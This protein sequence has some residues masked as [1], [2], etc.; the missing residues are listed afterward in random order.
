MTVSELNSIRYNA[1]K[2]QFGVDKLRHLQ[3]EIL[4][5]QLE[6]ESPAQY[7][8]TSNQHLTPEVEIAEEV[9]S[10]P[11]IVHPDGEQ[12]ED[13]YNAILTAFHKFKDTPV[14]E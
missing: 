4:N 12:N 13:L 1:M 5:A 11:L 3:L 6:G 8:S 2:N 9:P 7:D 14:D 10:E